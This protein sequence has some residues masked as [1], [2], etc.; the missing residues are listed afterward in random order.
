MYWRTG[1]CLIGK[2]LC[3]LMYSECNAI[4]VTCIFIYGY[5][6]M[7]SATTLFFMLRFIMHIIIVLTVDSCTTLSPSYSFSFPPLSILIP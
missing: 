3:P 6:M 1:I 7:A 2:L 5:C 4:A